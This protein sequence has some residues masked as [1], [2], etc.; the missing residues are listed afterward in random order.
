LS[1]CGYRVRTFEDGAKAFKAFEKDPDQ[2]DLIIT[3][4]T[5]PGMTGAEFSIRVLTLR[6]GIPIIL[7]TGYSE[8]F[9]EADA[10]ET[11]IR[12]YVQKPVETRSLAALIREILD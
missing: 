11:G 7:C 10:L 9:S 5:M 12:K 8:T 4:M 6:P 3:D 2:F 1:G